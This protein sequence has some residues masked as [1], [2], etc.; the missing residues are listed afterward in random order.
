MLILNIGATIDLADKE[1]R[2]HLI[3]SQL[4]KLDR[5]SGAKALAFEGSECRG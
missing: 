2:T 5:I 4:S 3:N 1:T